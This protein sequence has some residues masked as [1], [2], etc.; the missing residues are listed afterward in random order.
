MRERAAPVQRASH[1]CKSARGL[2][3]KSDGLNTEACKVDPILPCPHKE[4]H[5]SLLGLEVIHIR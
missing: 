1:E 5:G 2:I 3:F 4:V